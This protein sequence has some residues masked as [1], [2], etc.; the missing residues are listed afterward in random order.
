M[1]IYAER[2]AKWRTKEHSPLIAHPVTTLIYGSLD[3]DIVSEWESG[4]MLCCRN[5]IERKKG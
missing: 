3:G 4:R 5:K 1:A 2:S